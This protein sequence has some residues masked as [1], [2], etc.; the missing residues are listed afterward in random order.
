MPTQAKNI[1]KTSY[2]NV[3]GTPEQERAKMCAKAKYDMGYFDSQEFLDTRNQ[4]ALTQKVVRCLVSTRGPCEDTINVFQNCTR[5]QAQQLVKRLKKISIK[6]RNKQCQT[7]KKIKTN[8][9]FCLRRATTLLQS[10]ER[11]LSRRSSSRRF[12]NG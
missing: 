10:G 3:K 2:K 12:R 5:L 7:K 4:V 1:S 8:L 9:I 6:Q 11:Q